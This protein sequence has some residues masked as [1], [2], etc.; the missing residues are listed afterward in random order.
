MSHT[1]K[2]RDI[3]INTHTYTEKERYNTHDNTHIYTHE[4]THKLRQTYTQT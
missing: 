1:Q 2:A 3:H 4:Y